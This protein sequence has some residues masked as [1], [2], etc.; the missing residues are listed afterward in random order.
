MQISQFSGRTE[1]LVIVDPHSHVEN[2]WAGSGQHVLP[3]GGACSPQSSTAPVGPDLG[4]QVF[5]F[6][7]T[8]L[9][10][11]LMCSNHSLSRET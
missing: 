6:V 4:Y 11:P 2:T 10:Q 1:D 7:N 5:E 9:F 3:V 8:G